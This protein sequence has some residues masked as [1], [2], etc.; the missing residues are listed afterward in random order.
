[1]QLRPG[2]RLQ[3]VAC[4]TS[5]IVIRAPADDLD[6][7]CGGHPMLPAGTPFDPEE[8]VGDQGTG[9]LMGKRYGGDELG[10]ELLCTKAGPGLLSIGDEPIPM[11]E[12]KPLPSSD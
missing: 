3:S 5:V 6:I 7:R 2:A 9:T 11:K 12:A 4:T 8:A 1:M 10:V